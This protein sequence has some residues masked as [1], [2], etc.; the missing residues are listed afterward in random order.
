MAY[1]NS[2]PCRDVLSGDYEMDVMGILND[3]CR[4]LSDDLTRQPMVTRNC[5]LGDPFLSFIFILGFI[6]ILF[7]YLSLFFFLTNQ[8][9]SNFFTLDP[10]VISF[11]LT[12]LFDSFL[13]HFI[14]VQ[15]FNGFRAGIVAARNNNQNK[16]H[17][18]LN[19]NRPLSMN[20]CEKL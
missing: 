1:V 4:T 15:V 5:H 9:H 3:R 20:T 19:N 2:L 14:P 16:A 6:E 10:K 8:F 11:I 17:S 7:I 12:L 13:L 18:Y